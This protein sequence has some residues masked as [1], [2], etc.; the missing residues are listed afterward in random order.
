MRNLLLL[1]FPSPTQRQYFSFLL[2]LSLCLS[3][4]FSLFYLS[5]SHFLSG[6]SQVAKTVRGA[7]MLSPSLKALFAHPLFVHV[8]SFVLVLCISFVDFLFFSTASPKKNSLVSSSNIFQPHP[9]LITLFLLRVFI[10]SASRPL[11]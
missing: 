1:V 11:C 4:S 5:L 7:L 8:A 10:L 3:L 2:T 6:V 9:H